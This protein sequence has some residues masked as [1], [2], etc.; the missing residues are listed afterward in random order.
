MYC[1]YSGLN[2]RHHVN[3]VPHKPLHSNGSYIQIAFFPLSLPFWYS[4]PQIT[5]QPDSLANTTPGKPADFFV[6]ADGKHLSYTW[7]RQT[8]KQLL[9]SEQRVFV[10]STHVLH[11]DKVEPSD[12][13]Y[14]V[15]TI[16]NAT[17]G[18]VE[19]NPVQLTTST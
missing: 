18:S 2:Y 6:K 1:H 9:P 16:C 8:V 12:E 14:Y 7:H 10:R 15:C 5:E 19:T 13:G 11:I 17:D 4:V 3:Y